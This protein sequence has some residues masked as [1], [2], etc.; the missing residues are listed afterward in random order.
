MTKSVSITELDGRSVD[1]DTSANA[2]CQVVL[3]DG[4]VVALLEFEAGYSDAFQDLD[5]AVDQLM[6]N[7]SI[8][9][10]RV[11]DREV[12]WLRPWSIELT[13]LVMAEMKLPLDI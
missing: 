12:A 3:R 2:A 13:D 8:R 10:V 5:A 11:S 1:R 4:V 7:G 6:A 9:V